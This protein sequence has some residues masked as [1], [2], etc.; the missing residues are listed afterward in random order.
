[1]KIPF[2]KY[3]GTGNDFIMID[4]RNNDFPIY[5]FALIKAMCKSKFGIGADGLIVI[6]ES[7][8]AAFEMHYFNADGKPGS[9]CGNGGRC[10]VAFAA[11]HNFFDKNKIDFLAFD[12]LHHA[13]VD[14][15]M[16]HRKFVEVSLGMSNVNKYEW[17]GDDIFLDTGSPHYVTFEHVISNID[18]VHAGRKIR[19]NPRFDAT[20][21]NVNFV[22]T[23]HDTISVR[24]YERGVENETL[25]CGTG[26][27]ASAIAT[28]IMQKK[29][30][31][32]HFSV[33]TLGGNLEVSFARNKDLFSNIILKGPATHVFNGDIE[34]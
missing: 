1:M 4:G 33:K 9:M 7:E 27:T 30:G 22:E 5:D 3:H 13:Q 24:T 28:A 25:S 32:L 16:A 6:T 29:E 14:A 21:V 8:K 12:G 18:V 2:E 31:D 20:G 15:A 23:G 17:I 10:A 11:K 26:V 19:H 34:I